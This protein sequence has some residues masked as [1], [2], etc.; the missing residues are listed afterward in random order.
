MKEMSSS[1]LVDL[2][3]PDGKAEVDRLLSGGVDFKADGGRALVGALQYY[4]TA[5]DAYIATRDFKEYIKSG[6][7]VRKLAEGLYEHVRR[8][9]DAAVKETYVALFVKMIRYDDRDKEHSVAYLKAFRQA[10]MDNEYDLADAIFREVP[11]SADLVADAL[12]TDSLAIFSQ[13]GYL[14]LN[15]WNAYLEVMREMK[16]KD[17]EFFHAYVSYRILNYSSEQEL[18]ANLVAADDPELMWLVGDVPVVVMMRYVM[19]KYRK[20]RYGSVT[21]AQI[22][23]LTYQLGRLPA[24]EARDEMYEVLEIAAELSGDPD[25]AWQMKEAKKRGWPNYQDDDRRKALKRAREIIASAEQA[26]IIVQGDAV[27]G[28]SMPLGEAYRAGEIG[29]EMTKTI[30]KV[31]KRRFKYLPETVAG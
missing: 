2:S 20:P 21:P 9:S 4:P 23:S 16:K 12:Q 6:N 10:V 31:I 5:V 8:A 28:I 14:D 7:R 27:Y 11:L 15:E 26:G 18:L 3:I 30:Q 1:L 25:V 29:Q 19:W 17:A 22:V 13:P 24:S